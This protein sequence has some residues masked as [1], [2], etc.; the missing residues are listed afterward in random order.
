MSSPP[1]S[2]LPPSSSASP[3][4]LASPQAG[5]Q[6]EDFDEIL[7]PRAEQDVLLAG[8]GPNE[9]LR[10]LLPFHAHTGP[11]ALAQS[12]RLDAAAVGASQASAEHQGNSSA[13]SEVAR[14]ERELSADPGSLPSTRRTYSAPSNSS[15][16]RK[17]E[18]NRAAQ[19]RFRQR[20]KVLHSSALSTSCLH[21]AMRSIEI[22][23][24]LLSRHFEYPI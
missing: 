2:N 16:E 6:L 11:S 18:V 19:K 14:Q 13:S 20:Q 15:L 17:L 24:S 22:F 1:R 9:S 23:I 5:L 12:A 21:A 10:D 7:L 3:F 4:G 8:P